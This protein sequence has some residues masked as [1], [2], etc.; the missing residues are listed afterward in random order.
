MYNK[1]IMISTFL[2]SSTS[3]E[4]SMMSSAGCGGNGSITLEN[5]FKLQ[6]SIVI[7][8]ESIQF[9]E[10]LFKWYTIRHGFYQLYANNV[11]QWF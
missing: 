7:L 3:N 5:S 8:Y 11:K 1:Q 9:I 10:G 2:Y 4:Q 6:A